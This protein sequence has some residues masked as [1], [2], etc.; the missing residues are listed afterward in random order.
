MTVVLMILLS[1]ALALVLVWL[2]FGHQT[3]KTDLAAAALEIKNLLPI[4][5][6]HFP[7]IH[8]ILTHEDQKFIRQRAPQQVV[9]RWRAERRR[10]LRL[11]IRGL[12]Q[13]FRGLEKLARLLAALSPEIKRK[14]E[15]E[16]LWLGIQFRLLYRVTV[17]RFALHG[18][19]AEELVRLAEMLIDL[20]AT[21]EQS[22]NHMIEAFPQVQ[23]NPGV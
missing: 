10:I 7:Q 13:D 2:L 9:S 6:R 14:Q 18:L 16:W 3:P 4:H 23:A 19:P 22:T 11:Y 8:H 5:C 20:A 15:W 12:K 1:I 21:L 17:L